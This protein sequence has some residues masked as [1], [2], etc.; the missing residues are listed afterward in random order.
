MHFSRLKLPKNEEAR[1][2]IQKKTPLKEAFFSIFKNLFNCVF[3]NK[4][5]FSHP[6]LLVNQIPYTQREGTSHGIVVYDML[7]IFK[8]DKKL[9]LRV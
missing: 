1:K 5:M 9:I 7:G 6:S 4:Q 8:V 2:N 3:I